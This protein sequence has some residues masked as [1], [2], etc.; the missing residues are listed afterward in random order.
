[1]WAR[2][3]S[4][5]AAS[6]V[7]LER[8]QAPGSIPRLPITRG[9]GSAVVHNIEITLWRSRE[10]SLAVEPPTGLSVTATGGLAVRPAV[11]R[12]SIVRGGGL[13]CHRVGQYVQAS[14][15]LYSPTRRCYAI[16]TISGAGILRLSESPASPGIGSSGAL[17]HAPPHIGLTLSLSAIRTL[18]GRP[19]TCRRSDQ[20]V[21]VDVGCR[22]E[23]RAFEGR[24][25]SLSE[26]LRVGKHTIQSATARDVGKDVGELVITPA[27]SGHSVGM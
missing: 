9:P 21:S 20:A 17:T 13:H 4:M 1:M 3:S 12:T 10:A 19:V 8:L 15:A 27:T 25:R 7:A 16:S 24:I 5:P 22:N 11:S 18:C 26:G 6:Y 23:V 14:Q 2:S